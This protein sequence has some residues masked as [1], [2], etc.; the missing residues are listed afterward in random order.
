MPW[1]G[2][3]ADSRTTTRTWSRFV[4]SWAK[5]GCAERSPESRGLLGTPLGSPATGATSR[6]QR[7]KEATHEQNRRVHKP[8]AR[9]GYASAWPAGQG[10]SRRLRAWWLG[11]GLRRSG[12]GQG[13]RR[14]HG[15]YRRAAVWSTYL[16]DFYTVW[17]NRTDNPFTAV[18]NN[19]PKYVA[20]TTLE[21]PLPWSNS[22]LLK[23]DAAETVARLKEQP[24]KDLVILGS[25]EL[26]QSL[27]RSNLVDEYVLQIHPVVLGSGRRR[28]LKAVRSPLSG[29]WTPRRRPPA[30]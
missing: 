29:S 6:P 28:S 27:M 14:K 13:G 21:E 11:D 1:A 25:G 24:G 20:S 8:D 5:P 23:G 17:P 7:L 4:R 18:L 3:L 19:T 15:Q 30:W 22:T 12:H 2:S 9:R 16:R 26:V 10:S